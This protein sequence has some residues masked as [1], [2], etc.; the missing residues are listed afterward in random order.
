[1]SLP[2]EEQYDAWSGAD[3][4]S[5]DD[6]EDGSDDIGPAAGDVQDVATGA[7]DTTHLGATDDE[8][9]PSDEA[10]V[11]SA[12]DDERASSGEADDIGPAA[13]GRRRRSDW[14]DRRDAPRRHGR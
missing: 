14:C 4:D 8:R 2:P 5:D 6:S 10:D 7:I 12:T 9:A 13:G 3:A 1:M 11:E